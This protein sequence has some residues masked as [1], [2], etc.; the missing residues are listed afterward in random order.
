MGKDSYKGAI[1]GAIAVRSFEYLMLAAD[2]IVRTKH[3]NLSHF[4]NIEFCATML[5]NL[6]SV[7]KVEVETTEL[8]QNNFVTALSH[9]DGLCPEK[10]KKMRR[11]VVAVID[12]IIERNTTFLNKLAVVVIEATQTLAKNAVYREADEITMVSL[13]GDLKARLEATEFDT[14]L[15]QKDFALLAG[16]KVSLHTNVKKYKDQMTTLNSLLECCGL[17]YEIAKNYASRGDEKALKLMTD[18]FARINVVFTSEIPD[19][20]TYPWA[21][22]LD[23]ANKDFMTQF[24]VRDPALETLA[25][26]QAE[27]EASCQLC[28]MHM[29]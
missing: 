11:A 3:S 9:L 22:E 18:A 12:S 1:G 24:S 2:T 8:W 10:N 23:V 7:E 29:Y 20:G 17:T 13:V 4:D 19:L 26:A 25:M 15:S 6:E 16:G 5:N 14:C 28:C 21:K 27:L